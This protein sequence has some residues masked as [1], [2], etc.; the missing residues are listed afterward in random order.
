MR[1]CILSLFLLF[2]HVYSTVT[3]LDVKAEKRYKATLKIVCKIA[4][5]RQ[6]KEREGGKTKQKIATL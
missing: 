3:K 1:A 5:C 6:K 4:V 2:R